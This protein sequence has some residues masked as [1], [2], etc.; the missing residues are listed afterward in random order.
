MDS[1]Q[2]SLKLTFTTSSPII[3]PAL[4][5]FNH[6][7][8]IKSNHVKCP[9]A[10]HIQ[11]LLRWHGWL[12]GAVQ[13]RPEAPRLCRCHPSAPPLPGDL[14][15]AAAPCIAVDGRPGVVYDASGPT[16]GKPT[17]RPTM[18]RTKGLTLTPRKGFNRRC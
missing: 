16:G 5:S 4:N 14:D 3:G 17:Q 18:R 10:G 2:S 15:M 7:Y 9:K 12:A 1:A 6:N 11:V 8:S 13:G